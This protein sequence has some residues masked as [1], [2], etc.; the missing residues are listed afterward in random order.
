M[1]YQRDIING[2]AC[3]SG[4]CAANDIHFYTAG[5][6]ET[7]GT[8]GTFCVNQVAVFNQNP[9]RVLRFCAVIILEVAAVYRSFGGCPL[10]Q[11]FHGFCL[12][13]CVLR[14]YNICFQIRGFRHKHIINRCIFTIDGYSLTFGKY[15]LDFR[16]LNSFAV[17]L[18]V[19]SLFIVSVTCI[20]DCRYCFHRNV[21]CAVYNHWR[22]IQRSFF[23]VYCDIAGTNGKNRSCFIRFQCQ[24]FFLCVISQICLK[25]AGHIACRQE[26]KIAGGFCFYRSCFAVYIYLQRIV[27]CECRAGKAEQYKK[28]NSQ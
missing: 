16:N 21:G 7:N 6:G 1:I 27:R 8:A 3:C 5:F 12:T 9:V 4:Y 11:T 13:D 18:D 24:L 10:C 2:T 14:Q 28:N 17:F 20:P 26:Y 22:C 15:L 19:Q 25:G 23:A